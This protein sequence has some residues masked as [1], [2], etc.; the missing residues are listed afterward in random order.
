[1]LNAYA[2]AALSGTQQ[3]LWVQS[4]LKRT[5][6]PQNSEQKAYFASWN[7]STQTFGSQMKS[8]LVNKT[9]G[10]IP[11]LYFAI[12]N[13]L[14]FLDLC[15]LLQNFKLRSS[16]MTSLPNYTCTVGWPTVQSSKLPRKKNHNFAVE[17]VGTL[18]AK[19][20]MTPTSTLSLYPGTAMRVRPGTST[21]STSMSEMADL[22][23][24]DQ[25]TSLLDR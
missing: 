8:M 11:E 21:L 23:V 4:L 16:M 17:V 1:M 5:P 19:E 25:L 2:A 7:I 12:K 9:Y 10:I 14:I 20:M 3:A 15:E 13:R 22:R 6:T 18:Y 24:Q